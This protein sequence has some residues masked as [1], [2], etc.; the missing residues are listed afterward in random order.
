MVIDFHHL[1]V[2]QCWPDLQVSKLETIFPTDL[3]S[4]ISDG[5]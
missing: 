4:D 1:K 2:E 5:K 3:A